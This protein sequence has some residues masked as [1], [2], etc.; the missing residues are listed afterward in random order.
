[1]KRL[2]VIVKLE[3]REIS[4]GRS[5]VSLKIKNVGEEEIETLEVGLSSLNQSLLEVQDS[6]KWLSNIQ[7]DETAIVPFDISAFSSAR[8]YI[9]IFGYVDND[10]FSW[11]S[12][13][14]RLKVGDEVAEIDNLLIKGDAN[15]KVGQRVEAEATIRGLKPDSKI[16]LDYW[17]NMPNEVFTHLG[18]VSIEV[19]EID[20]VKSRIEFTPES[21]G[22]YTVYAY[23]YDGLRQIDR[24]IDKVLITKH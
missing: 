15:Q 17:V 1:M 14:I 9:K 22:L 19:N 3:P 5:Q 8:V 2:P 23:L 24:D 6:L 20:I 13:G 7:P 10:R 4:R 21:E 12:P 16:S 18:E 11:E